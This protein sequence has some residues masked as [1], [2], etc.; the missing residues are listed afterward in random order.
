MIIMEA[1]RDFVGNVVLGVICGGAIFWL[2]IK[3]IVW[4]AKMEKK[5]NRKMGWDKPR[6]KNTV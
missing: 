4:G 3:F 6:K 1:M 2:F 5:I